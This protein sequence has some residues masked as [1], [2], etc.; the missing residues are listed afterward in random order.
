[1]KLFVLTYHSHHV[2]GEA[3]PL[4]D[5]VA[6]AEDLRAIDSSGYRI[7]PLETV[8]DTVES[9]RNDGPDLVAL[10]FD[11][12][13]I[14][15]VDDF[16]HPAFGPQPSFLNS[17]RRFQ[18]DFGP[19]RQPGLHATSFVIAS[20]GARTVME[21]NADLQYTYLEPDS[22][23]VSWWNYAIS[24]R[25]IGIAN[26]SWDH[27]HPA[28]PAVA[29]SRN[30]R[31]DFTQVDNRADADAQIASAS[32]YISRATHSLASPFFAYPFGHV[33]DYL[34]N[35]YFPRWGLSIGIR[36]A[37]TTQP[38]SILPQ[39]SRWAL[40]RVTCGH[41]WKSADELVTRLLRPQSEAA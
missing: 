24:T 41:H 34:V 35:E 4:N 17:M 16:V 10:T 5:H 28:L 14:Y 21:T 1:M 20:S 29:H 18:S 13:P 23:T 15:D 37:F 7:V 3:Y 12:G 31:A 9:G 8:V 30:A 22:M 36:A 6:F 2:V 38:R 19:D 26:H 40:P 25:L 11:D 33:N 32:S 39:D 27:L